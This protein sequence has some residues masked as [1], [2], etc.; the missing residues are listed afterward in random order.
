VFWNA[1]DQP[2]VQSLMCPL[3]VVVLDVLL[4]RSTKMPFAD[5]HDAIQALGFDR[6]H[7]SLGEG[8]QIR[9]FAA[10]A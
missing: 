5:W 2:I 1:L 6:E 8:V 4:D 9:P 7:E 3:G 10:A